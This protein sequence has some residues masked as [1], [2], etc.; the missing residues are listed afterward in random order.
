M[1]C[2]IKRLDQLEAPCNWTDIYGVFGLFSL[3]RSHTPAFLSNTDFWRPKGPAPC[4]LSVPGLS[5]CHP[6]PC[7]KWP[8]TPWAHSSPLQTF[9]I[10]LLQGWSP[11]EPPDPAQATWLTQTPQCMSQKLHRCHSGWVVLASVPVSTAS[12]EGPQGSSAT[13]LALPHHCEAHPH[14]SVLLVLT[15]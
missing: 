12:G 14:S 15:S 9:S 10:T 7:S 3:C 13:K 8:Q 11:P 6:S 1:I 4:Q 2:C 5:L